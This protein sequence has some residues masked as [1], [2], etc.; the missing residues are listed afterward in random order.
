VS[1]KQFTETG[2]FCQNIQIFPWGTITGR[3]L[4]GSTDVVCT[5]KWL[6]KIW[7][8]RYCLKPTKKDSYRFWNG[9]VA[10]WASPKQNS[11]FFNRRK[12]IK[13][14]ANGHAD[15]FFKSGAA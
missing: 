1:E 10:F 11:F 12:L 5:E 9:A 4:A 14:S 13:K 3:S 15:G 8:E 6:E 7:L 2:P